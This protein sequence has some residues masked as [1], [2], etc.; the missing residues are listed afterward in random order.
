MSEENV[1]FVRRAWA[2]FEAG[3]LSSALAAL[4]PELVTYVAP[5][6]PVTGTYHGPEGF[7]QVT[8]D[9]AEGFD[10]LVMTGEEFIDAGDQVVVRALHKSHGAESGVPV[11]TGVWYVWTIRDGKAIRADIF[12]E[13][14]EALEA[15]GLS[16]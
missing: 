10:D 6:I 16:E 2:A 14:R 9:W 3:D 11:E 8:I 4:S 15:A 13:R 7:L 1:K 12:N 5:P